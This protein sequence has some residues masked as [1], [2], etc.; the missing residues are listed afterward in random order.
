MGKLTAVAVK[1]ALTN[2]GTYQDGDG[3]VLRVD[4]RGGA[5]WLLRI[6]RDGKRQDIG[7]G[8]PKL[9]TLAEARAK[10][11]D[12]RKAVKVEKRDV[13]TERK[14]EEAAKVT[15]TIGCRRNGTASARPPDDLCAEVKDC[16]DG[17]PVTLQ[18]PRRHDV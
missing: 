5:Y 7:L 4:K 17:N 1:A 14:D 11:A 6:Q 9:V 3:L 12:L 8:S 16:H 18:T 2:P 13:L 15:R 10:A